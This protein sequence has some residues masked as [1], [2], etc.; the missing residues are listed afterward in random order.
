MRTCSSYGSAI[1]VVSSAVS[2]EPVLAEST[3]MREGRCNAKFAV[4]TVVAQLLGEDVYA[5]IVD[6][7]SAIPVVVDVAFAFQP[8]REVASTPVFVGWTALTRSSAV[9]QFAHP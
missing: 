5:T 4:A 1:S 2:Y 3:E 7:E 9:I 6:F 8:V